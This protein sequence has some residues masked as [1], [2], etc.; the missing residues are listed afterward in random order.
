MDSPP[1]DEESPFRH[2]LLKSVWQ[3]RGFFGGILAIQ[4][5]YYGQRA[6]MD[7][8]DYTFSTF[9]YG[10][11][12]LVLILSLLHPNLPRRRA[13]APTA[14]ATVVDTPE[15]AAAVDLAAGNGHT[16]G[17]TSPAAPPEARVSNATPAALPM[18]K[19]GS[20]SASVAATQDSSVEAPGNGTPL[21]TARSEP[22][23]PGASTDP[24]GTRKAQPN[25]GSTPQTVTLV[26]AESTVARTAWQRIPKAVARLAAWRAREGWRVTVPALLVA[27]GLL[28]WSFFALRANI[29]EPVGGWLWAGGLVA[30]WV[31]LLGVPGWQKGKSLLPGPREEFFGRGVPG[32]DARWS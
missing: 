24:V 30:L 26:T 21:A 15:A 22:E 2:G 7:R 27:V 25:N 17:A 16:P 5:A 4:I 18:R 8:D 3:A 6:L 20:G 1:P 9:C 11:A 19:A 23:V 13:A 14:Q 32:L 10:L 12:I 31:A 29:V 28:V